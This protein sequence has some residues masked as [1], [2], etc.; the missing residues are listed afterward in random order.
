MLEQN[1]LAL[2]L[3]RLKQ[4]QQALDG[5]LEDLTRWLMH[6]GTGSDTHELLE[7]LHHSVAQVAILVDK[8]S[9]QGS[10]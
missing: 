10:A 3:M 4:S 5:A 6:H 1:V 2:H 8:L 7:G 9:R